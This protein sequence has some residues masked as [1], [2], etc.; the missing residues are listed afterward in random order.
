MTPE[1]AENIVNA[2]GGIIAN[3]PTGDR[4]QDVLSLPYSPARIRYAFFVYT[5]AL[6]KQGLFNDDLKQNLET[7]Y[8]LLD[9][10]FIEGD[11]AK[12]NKALRLYAKNEKARDY[13]NANGGLAVGMPSTARMV[14]YHNFVVDC[15]GNWGKPR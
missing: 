7:T 5:E 9:T 1:E 10:R 8:A 2:Y 13:V 3:I 6:I 12:L 15:Y 11:V 14:E 4:V